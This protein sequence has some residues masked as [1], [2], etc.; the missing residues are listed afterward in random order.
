VVIPLI[1][2][3]Q[4][5]REDM[6]SIRYQIRIDKEGD[7]YIVDTENKTS[8]D[9]PSLVAQYENLTSAAIACTE[10]NNNS[11]IIVKADVNGLI[12]NLVAA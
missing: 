7:C 4:P 10:L 1:T 8:K 11:Q 3:S 6:A 9:K 2:L 12:Q 5:K